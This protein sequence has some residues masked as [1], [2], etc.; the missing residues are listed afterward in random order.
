[1]NPVVVYMTAQEYIRDLRLIDD[2]LD[3]GLSNT[4]QTG[5]GELTTVIK[6]IFGLVDKE[7]D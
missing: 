6:D 1:M 7:E 2:R 4:I 3:G 5:S